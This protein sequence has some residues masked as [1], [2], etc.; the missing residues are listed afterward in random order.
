MSPEDVVPSEESQSREDTARSAYTRSLVQSDAQRCKG[1]ARWPGQ[2]SGEGQ[3]QF[4]GDRVLVRQGEAE[5]RG[6]DGG[7]GRTPTLCT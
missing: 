7:D 1:Q 5:L 4:H 6:V 3:L 2:G